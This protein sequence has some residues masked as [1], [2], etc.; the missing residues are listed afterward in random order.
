MP[1]WHCPINGFPT[2]PDL[3]RIEITAVRVGELRL[4]G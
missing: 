2:S 1:N 3:K 4:G